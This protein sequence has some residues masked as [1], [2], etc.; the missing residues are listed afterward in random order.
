MNKKVK[1]SSPPKQDA[2]L[3]EIRDENKAVM[4]DRSRMPEAVETGRSAVN[5]NYFLLFLLL[6][7]FI[8]CYNIIKPYLNTIVLAAILA[9]IFSPIHLKIEKKLSGRKNTAAFFS[10][11]LITLVVVLPLVLMLIALIGQG[12]SSFN[13]IYDWIEAGKYQKLMEHPLITGLLER[14]DLWLPDL[15]KYFPNMQMENIQI[16]KMVLNLTAS[17]GKILIDQGGNL[18]G[19]LSALVGKFFMMLFT[20]FFFIRDE[21]KITDAVLHL[22]PLSASQEEKILMKI[23][24]VA[25]SALL[26]TLV[27]ALAQGAAGGIAFWITGLPGFFWGMMMAFASLIP[28][29]GT[30]LIWIPAAVFLFVSGHWGYGIFMVLWCLVVVGMIDN[31]IRP[32]FMQG[33]ADMSTLLIFFAILGGLNYFGLIGLLYGPLIF[34]LAMV[35]LYIYQ[36][37]FELFLDRQDRA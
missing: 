37:E 19:N 10:C 22:I 31:L 9:I 34:G 15:Q 17:T 35:L 24:T 32:L 1:K 21:K 27:T 29:V 7:V 14:V 16:D 5:K 6:I 30:A 3:S 2:G 18:A 23:K 13:A 25:K 26:G 20:F 36:L 12:I 28:M 11:I 33:T 4:D 8:G